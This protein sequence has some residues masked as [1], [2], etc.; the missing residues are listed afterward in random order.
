VDESLRKLRTDYVDL[1]LL[2]WPSDAT[3]L[4]EQIAGLNAAM[5][6]SKVRHIG[7]SN[8]N[9]TLMAEAVKLSAVPIVTNQFEYYPYLNQTLLI[10]QC[11]RLDVSVTA[12][13][14]MAVGRVFWG[15]SAPGDWQSTWEERGA[16]RTALA[17]AT[18]C[19]RAVSHRECRARH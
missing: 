15:S 19:N 1:L 14:G 10:D 4:A 6:A 17:L 3:P 16:G 7:V 11:R 12:Y 2:H 13:R 8:F 18:R 9:R 5:H